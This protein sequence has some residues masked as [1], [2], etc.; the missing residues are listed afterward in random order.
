MTADPR[1]LCDSWASCYIRWQ[2]NANIVIHKKLPV[3]QGHNK[4]RSPHR[5]KTPPYLRRS[6]MPKC[7]Q[8][9]RVGGRFTLH[10]RHDIDAVADWRGDHNARMLLQRLQRSVVTVLWSPALLLLLLL[11]VSAFICNDAAFRTS[12]CR[13]SRQLHSFTTCT[14]VR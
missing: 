2:Q 1:Y 12:T 6:V 4:Q 10:K 11:Q 3:P 7:D 14:A 9:E 13:H 8:N 5:T